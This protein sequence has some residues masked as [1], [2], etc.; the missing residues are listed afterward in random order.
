MSPECS[1]GMLRAGAVIDYDG[2]DAWGLGR[3][4][5]GMLSPDERAGGP[6]PGGGGPHCY[7]DDAYVLPADA[8]VAA[9]APRCGDRV[10]R[11][12]AG[13]IVRDLLRVDPAARCSLDAAV[14]RLE[15]LLFVLLLR[16]PPGGGR[17]EFGGLAWL[18]G[19][20]EALQEA[21]LAVDAA[22]A[23]PRVIDMLLID[24]A[25]SPRCTT[26]AVAGVLRDLM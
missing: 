14:A 7:R 18:P 5:W 21:A 9:A 1:R 13:R 24:Y 8:A 4:L 26:G 17:D 12:A 11:V 20:L 16:P 23:P 19:A 3:V 6:F 15:A 2:Q 10:F 25:G 22:A